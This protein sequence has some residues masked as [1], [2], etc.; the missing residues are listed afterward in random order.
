MNTL[1][2]Q[3]FWKP[4]ASNAKKLEKDCQILKNKGY[5]S[6]FVEKVFYNGSP[7]FF[8]NIFGGKDKIAITTTTIYKTPGQDALEAKIVL[9]TSTVDAKVPTILSKDCLIALDVPSHAEAIELKTTLTSIK[10]DNFERTIDILSDKTFQAPLNLAATN[11][12]QVLTVAKL[13]N[14]IFSSDPQRAE[15]EGSYAGL[16]SQDPIDHPVEN[17]RLTDGYLILIS[18]NDKQNNF[19]DNFDSNLL[20]YVDKK[21]LYNNSHVKLTHIIYSIQFVEMRGET[22]NTS[23]FKQ[24]QKAFTKLEDLIGATTDTEIEEIKKEVIQEW[25]KGNLLLDNDS[26]YTQREKQLIKKRKFNEIKKIFQENE[27]LDSFIS[28]D[29]IVEAETLLKTNNAGAARGFESTKN[30]SSKSESYAA[31]LFNMIDTDVQ[32]YIALLENVS[33]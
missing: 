1:G 32:E 11:M 26:T 16:I 23:W 2:T 4:R 25:K 12:G 33:S 27:S 20:T 28:M 6:I 15:L 10:K 22:E 31:K 13:V 21:L 9:G 7:S 19:W 14:R 24:Y 5:I 8:Q 30:E 29:T 17:N 3:N 18:N